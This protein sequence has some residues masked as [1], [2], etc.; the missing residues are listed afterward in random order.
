MVLPMDPSGMRARLMVAPRWVLALYYGVFFG[1][2]ISLFTGIRDS[3]V[4]GGVVAG[5]LEGLI[6]S[7]I[8]TP[9]TTLMRER[10]RA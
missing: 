8:M 1:V 2:A 4:L 9:L 7:A 5:L 3:S 10:M 6:F